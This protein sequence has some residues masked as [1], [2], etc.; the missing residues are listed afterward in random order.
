MSFDKRE[1]GDECSA[2]YS[3]SL[4]S[5][6]PG[7]LVDLLTEKG[8]SDNEIFN[9]LGVDRESLDAPGHKIPYVEYVKLRQRATELTKNPAIGL[10]LGWRLNLAGNGF[11]SIGA[12]ACENMIEAMRFI[13]RFSPIINPAVTF[14]VKIDNDF[15]H[16]FI[17]SIYSEDRLNACLID[18]PMAIFSS[19]LQL[20][21]ADEA[22]RVIYHMKYDALPCEAYYCQW[23]K[24]QLFFNMPR[25][26]VSFP[27]DMASKTMPFSNP[28]VVRQS[29]AD[30]E[31][32]LAAQCESHHSLIE[33]VRQLAVGESGCVLTLEEVAAKLHMSSRTLIRRLNALGSSFSDITNEVRESL[34]KGYLENSRLSIEEISFLLGYKNSSNFSKAFR[35]WVG[36]SPSVY[37][38]NHKS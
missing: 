13:T 16:V 18:T 1:T 17:D 24:G 38:L 27:M 4:L 11:L 21:P 29:E 9:N 26:R 19:A 22:Q 30:L 12:L 28:R 25:N 15:L 31:V 8:F 2:Q 35:R 20:Y 36:C 32:Q 10:E 34:S 23:L 6:H 7:A 33:D 14:E 5:S 3:G 37:R